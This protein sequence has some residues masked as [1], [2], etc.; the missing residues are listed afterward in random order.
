MEIAKIWSDYQTTLSLCSDKLYSKDYVWYSLSSISVLEAK[1][2]SF[3]CYN[4][5]NSSREC[6]SQSKQA[7]L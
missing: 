7:A 6:F 4:T 1:S 3:S 2:F 5:V